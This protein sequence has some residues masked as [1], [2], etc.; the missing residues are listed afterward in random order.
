MRVRKAIDPTVAMAEAEKLAGGGTSTAVA[1]GIPPSLTSPEVDTS[2]TEAASLEG[3]PEDNTESDQVDEQPQDTGVTEGTAAPN[4]GA[5][6]KPT[7]EAAFPFTLQRKGKEYGN[8]SYK[9]V[10]AYAQMGMNHDIKGK[11]LNALHAQVAER[12]SQMVEREK[13]LQPI[14]AFDEWMRSDPQLA[15]LVE[16][17]VWDYQQSQQGGQ[18]VQQGGQVPQQAQAPQQ[19]PADPRVDEMYQFVKD[20]QQKSADEQLDR[21][22]DK[23]RSGHPNT[24]WDVPDPNDAEGRTP[25]EKIYDFMTQHNLNDPETAYRALFYDADLSAREQ[26][27]KQ[28]VSESIQ[29]KHR[30]GA[31]LAGAMPTN[32]E[33]PSFNFDSMRNK[34]PNDIAA[35]LQRAMETGQLPV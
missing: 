17:T 21:M 35:A 5:A 4:Q 3:G 31:V 19:T 33:P 16:Q 30:Q 32:Q 2:A 23:L 9:D 25:E 26:Q 14:V 13:F 29:R 20:M 10:I 8:L 28:S 11:E 24:R 6:N 1:E 22:M 7:P 34:R 12:Q 18:Q 27:A 15:A